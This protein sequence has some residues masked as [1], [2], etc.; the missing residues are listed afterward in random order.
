[1]ELKIYYKHYCTVSG[2]VV[3]E[4]KKLYYN[5]LIANSENKVKMTWKIIKNLTGKIQNSQHASPTFNIDGVEQSPKQA[6]ETFNNYFLNITE[7][8]NV[9]FAND[10]NPISL[11]KKYHPFQFPP[12]Q[13]VPITEGEIR[14]V[15]SSLKSTNS[16]GYDG[17]STKILKL[18]GNQISKPLAFIFN[19]SITMGVFPEQLQYA[20]LIP[21]HKK[22]DV[23]N[24]ANYRPI[25][26][27]LK[28]FLKEQCI[29][30]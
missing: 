3:R 26:L 9:H 5:E 10:N 23:S 1:L 16:S 4:A 11:L 25:S 20:V 13:I 21:L 6:A 19:K 22:G 30:D 29:V 8:L 27:F 15:I 17:I 14:S 28:L 24:V 2:R 18:C 7:N 12:V